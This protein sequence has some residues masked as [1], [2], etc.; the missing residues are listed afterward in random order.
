MAKRKPTFLVCVDQKTGS[1][2]VLLS[3]RCPQVTVEQTQHCLNPGSA[4]ET[5]WAAYGGPTPQ[6]KTLADHFVCQTGTQS[7]CM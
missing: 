4:E 3:G 7:V 2:I 1:A 6:I 5:Q